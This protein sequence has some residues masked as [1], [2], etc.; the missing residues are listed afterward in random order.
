MDDVGGL[1]VPERMQRLSAI[2]TQHPR[3]GHDD[4]L[5]RDALVALAECALVCA[6]CADACG[7]EPD[8]GLDMCIRLDVDCAT[9][10]WSTALLL[11]RRPF[12]EPGITMRHLNTCAEMC[13]RCAAECDRH[14]DRHSHCATCAAACEQCA[15]A[16]ER[17]SDRLRTNAE[18]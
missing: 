15:T 6:V 4:D 7:N 14:G 8:D 10:C 3:S 9:L 12:V 11:T 13:R 1:R 18:S 5:L 17:L 16:C 2:V